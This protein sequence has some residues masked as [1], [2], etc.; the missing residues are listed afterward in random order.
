[1]QRDQVPDI[2]D[3]GAIGLRVRFRVAHSADRRCQL[4]RPGGQAG[5][6]GSAPVVQRLPDTRQAAQLTGQRQ[7][8][9]V[10]PRA[11]KGG[12]PRP[13]ERPPSYR[14]PATARLLRLGRTGPP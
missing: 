8:T 7:A 11:A 13:R 1:M 10:S 5:S 12:V 2:L 4:R 9:S 14:N 6:P 3:Q